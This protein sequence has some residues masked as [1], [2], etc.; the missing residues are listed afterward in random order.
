MEPRA[1]AALREVKLDFTLLLVMEAVFLAAITLLL[2]PLG[3][4][5]LALT[6][7]KGFGAFYLTVW[8]VFVAAL[9]LM[10][11]LRVDD[12]SRFDA[13]LFGN[14]AAGAVPLLGWTA[15]AAVAVR[16]A[17]SGAPLPAA[18]L[19]WLVGLF[20]AHMAFSVVSTYYSGSFYRSVNL[21]LAGAG[22]AV[23][24]LWPAA[25]RFLF[26]WFFSLW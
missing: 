14:L 16:S 3:H 18:L 6:L 4:L 20:T 11:W 25:G 21:P 9:L 24:A 7:M 2:W 1:E 10:R 22:F 23:F 13:Y 8:V 15:F 26:G 19:L 5:A 17:A 12:D